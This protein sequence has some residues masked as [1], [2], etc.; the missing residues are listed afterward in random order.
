MNNDWGEILRDEFNQPYFRALMDFVHEE[1]Q[2]EEVYPPEED[3]FNALRYTSY[4]DTKVVIVGQDPYINP[5]QAHGLSFSVLPGARI[6]PSL[7]NIFV[8]LHDDC[9][10]FI[11][12]N[13]CLIPWAEQGVLLL[14]SVLTVRRGQSNSHANIGW[15]R[16]TDRIIELLNMKQESIVFMLWGNYAR[17]RKE[18]LID[19]NAHL[20]LTA[21][22]PSPLAGGKFFGCA[23]F[24]RANQF[25]YE[26]SDRTI[27]WQI[28]NLF[29]EETK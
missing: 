24:S 18:Y 25:L 1:Y 23:H 17:K 10:C 8:E 7:H 20:V 26:I 3:M 11:P 27:D 21:P 16:F 2:R 15:E 6:P 9:G 5:G 4:A 14:N 13:G 19:P 29:K 22:H 28:P 12:D